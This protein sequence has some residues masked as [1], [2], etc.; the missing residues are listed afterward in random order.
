MRSKC[1]ASLVAEPPV[2]STTHIQ[3]VVKMVIIKKTVSLSSVE[4]SQLRVSTA[5]VIPVNGS[6]LVII[7]A[8]H[9]YIVVAAF[10]LV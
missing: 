7:L 8:L 5:L 4:L 1:L 10:P 2:T 9:G 3:Q 6:I